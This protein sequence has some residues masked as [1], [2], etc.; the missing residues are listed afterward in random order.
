[1]LAA[2]KSLLFCGESTEFGPSRELL[3]GWLVDRLNVIELRRMRTS[4]SDGSYLQLP[5]T[6]SSSSFDLLD[7]SDVI[8]DVIS[9]VYQTERE[10]YRPLDNLLLIR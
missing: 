5:V 8:A 4:C 3:T 1:M 2:G 10:A 6:A 9:E 7:C